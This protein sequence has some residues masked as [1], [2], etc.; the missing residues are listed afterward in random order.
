MFLTIL[1]VNVMHFIIPFLSD[2]VNNYRRADLLRTAYF[3]RVVESVVR[4]PHMR[5]L[6]QSI[7]MHRNTWPKHFI[8]VAPFTAIGSV[9]RLAFQ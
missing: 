6:Q 1:H 9:A 5:A 4:H 3:A 2:V 8:P 7:N